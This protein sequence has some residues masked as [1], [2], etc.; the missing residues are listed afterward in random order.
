MVQSQ[1][2]ADNQAPLA[3]NANQVHNPIHYNHLHPNATPYASGT[4]SGSPSTKLLS[5]SL[6]QLI[7]TKYNNPAAVSLTFGNLLDMNGNANAH[8]SNL[9][10]HHR[11]I[12]P[13]SALNSADLRFS[14]YLLNSQQGM[15]RSGRIASSLLSQAGQNNRYQNSNYPYGQSTGSLTMSNALSQSYHHSPL[16]ST[17]HSSRV[18]ALTSPPYG[19][20]LSSPRLGNI[21]NT[22]TSQHTVLPSTMGNMP[23]MGYNSYASLLNKAN[24]LF[25][26]SLDSM[27]LDW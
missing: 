1:R 6:A 19:S 10:D 16:A 18:T 27:M 20:Q 9:S 15:N 23:M 25:E 13:T 8:D 4:V 3:P 14:D 22:S 11:L 7:E 12:N 5:P 21:N 17:P 24:L 26:N 2:S